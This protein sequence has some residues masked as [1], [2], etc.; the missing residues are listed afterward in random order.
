MLRW[1]ALASAFA[2]RVVRVD[3]E[4]APLS[5]EV[6]TQ[7]RGYIDV[8]STHSPGQAP[9][10]FLVKAS[11]WA[12][13]MAH[14][15]ERLNETLG[16]ERCIGHRGV[17]VVVAT[18]REVR[19]A[20][21][22]ILVD[23]P[24]ARYLLAEFNAHVG[25][26]VERPTIPLTEEAIAVLQEFDF[27]QQGFF[28]RRAGRSEA[29][30]WVGIVAR[31]GLAWPGR[32]ALW[33]W[34]YGNGCDEAAEARIRDAAFEVFEPP[35]TLPDWKACALVPLRIAAAPTT[36]QLHGLIDQIERLLG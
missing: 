27:G 10:V 21:D 36:E 22:G 13:R 30:L 4:V 24:V 9:L 34:L 6:E 8:L 23:D 11:Q 16:F 15:R 19:E 7:V 25:L 1:P 2:K 29:T 5:F 33:A 14:I 26:D 20:F 35:D 17:S 12:D 28:V 31:A 3:S 32:G 18:W